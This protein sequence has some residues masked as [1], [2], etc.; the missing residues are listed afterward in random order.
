MCFMNVYAVCYPLFPE[1]SLIVL[2]GHLGMSLLGKVTH[3]KLN[4]SNMSGHMVGHH[5]HS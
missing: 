4:N 2:W 5:L 1:V 3:N